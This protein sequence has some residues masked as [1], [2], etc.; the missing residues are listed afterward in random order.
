MARWGTARRGKNP[1]KDCHF[2]IHK[3]TY[4][5]ETLYIAVCD[6]A[7][8]KMFE[9]DRKKNVPKMLANPIVSGEEVVYNRDIGGEKW[10]KVGN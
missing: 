3:V 8:C 1:V 9:G 2:S 7:K 4:G 5:L 6:T 10:G